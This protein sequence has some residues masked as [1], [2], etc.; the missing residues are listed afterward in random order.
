MV[1]MA[2]APRDL[3]ERS[4]YTAHHALS[5]AL[6]CGKSKTKTETTDGH[7]CCNIFLHGSMHFKEL[8]SHTRTQ[9]RANL[10]P[11]T[12]TESSSNVKRKKVH[13]V[14]QIRSQPRENVSPT[15]KPYA[16]PR[17][18]VRQSTNK[19]K[20]FRRVRA[21]RARL[22]DVQQKKKILSTDRSWS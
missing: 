2:P 22:E 12:T 18:A 15:K 4:I 14:A 7:E 3:V 21:A 11:T 16:S 5:F 10:L 19:H 9:P 17:T 13:L 8:R 6:E 20:T 1:D